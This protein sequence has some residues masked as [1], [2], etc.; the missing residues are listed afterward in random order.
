MM[1]LLGLVLV[2]FFETGALSPYPAIF[3]S[4]CIPLGIAVEFRVLEFACLESRSGLINGG[5]REP[6]PSLNHS[7]VT[8]CSVQYPP[9]PFLEKICC[10]ARIM[11]EYS[12]SGQGPGFD[13]RAS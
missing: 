10:L 6:D 2:C 11:G 5:L 4:P 12:D 13:R 1:F 9:L 8:R 3:R 7:C